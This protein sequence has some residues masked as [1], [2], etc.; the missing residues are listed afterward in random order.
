MYER[1][2]HLKNIYEQDLDKN[3]ANYAHLTPL[4]FLERCASVYPK[5]LSVINARNV[6][7]FAF[8][9]VVAASET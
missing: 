6:S 5:R 7:L 4:N 9:A 1:G 8:N 3:S 2:I